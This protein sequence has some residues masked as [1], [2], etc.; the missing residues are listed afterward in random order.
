[1]LPLSEVKSVKKEDIVEWAL[2]TWYDKCPHE[3]KEFEE[4]MAEENQAHNGDT[5]SGSGE[6]MRMG[7]IPLTV[8]NLIKEVDDWFW[9]EQ[10]NNRLFFEK[11]AKARV[12]YN[13]RKVVA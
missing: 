9:N 11:F 2:N 4:F 13:K 3:V 10:S 5:M 6:F 8:Y 7:S 1:M 12:W